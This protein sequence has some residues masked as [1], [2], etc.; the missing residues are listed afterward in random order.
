MTNL[1]LIKLDP[2]LKPFEPLIHNRY[3]KLKATLNS[4][5]DFGETILDF[6]TAHHYY[7]LHKTPQGWIFR[8]WAPNA[9]KIF[10]VG[11]FSNWKR[12]EQY[13]LKSIGNGNWEIVLKTSLLKHG[14]LFKLFMQWPNGSGD[15]LPSYATRVVQDSTTHIFSAQ[16]WHPETPY[17]F[18]CSNYQPHNE[19]PI[20]YEAHIGMS[21]EASRMSSYDEFREEILPRIIKGGY[22]TIQFMAIQEHPYYG[23]FGYHVSNYFA[24][25]SKFGTPESLKALIDEAHK[26]GINVIMDM[27]HSHAVKNEVEGISCFDGTYDQFFYPGEKGF[28]P[29][30]DSR[31]FDYSKKEVLRFLLSNIRFWM[32]E[33][34]FDGYR[35][36]GVTSMLYYNHGLEIDFTSY[37]DYFKGQE[38]DNAMIYLALANEI[39]H[40]IKPKALSI[41]EE[42][43][44]YP[45][46]CASIEDGGMGFD[47]RLSMG[48]PD[49]WIKMVKDTPDEDWSMGKLYHELTQHRPEEKTINY[50]ESHDQALVGD[51]TLIFRLTDK[52][53]YTHMAKSTPSIIVDRGIALHKMIRLLT[54]ATNAGGY[55]NFM[56]N[57]FGHPEWVDFPREGNNWSYHYARRQ[58]SLCDNNDLKYHWLNDFDVDMIHIFRKAIQSG[59]PGCF[60]VS[61]NEH[62][63]ILVFARGEWVFIFNFNPV[64]SFTDYGISCEAGKYRIVLNSDNEKYGGFKRIDEY[65]TYYSMPLAKQSHVHELKLYLPNR[66]ALVLQKL[67]ITKVF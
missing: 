66:T 34:Q 32:E 41:A 15:R 7:G 36:D 39:I 57:E 65:Y 35:F 4:L 42:M 53:M 21:S 56:G 2:W 8:E 49:F 29:A 26:N 19:P 23:S 37:N 50:A 47:Y 38:D 60:L 40:T 59:M 14:D 25:T 28:H 44:G 64:K 12:Q 58:W 31:C 33:Y 30:W 52:E 1:G 13:E 6:A 3:N 22:N 46:L 5:L 48:V 18:N 27:V 55:L 24:A 43:S 63:K 17:S 10:L 61:A 45:G 9:T 11:D 16:V 51:K 20:I 67:P 62:D 54:L